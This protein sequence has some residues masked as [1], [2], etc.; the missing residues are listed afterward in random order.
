MSEQKTAQKTEPA[1]NYRLPSDITLKR[2]ESSPRRIGIRTNSAF[3][4]TGPSYV[5]CTLHNNKRTAFEPISIAANFISKFE[6]LLKTTCEVR[7]KYKILKF[8]ISKIL[9][10]RILRPNSNF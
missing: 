4:K 7:Y 10:N 9:C 3:L 8:H 1:L 5:S 6:L 2:K